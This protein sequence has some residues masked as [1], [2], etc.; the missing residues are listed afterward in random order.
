M[1][2]QKFPLTNSIKRSSLEPKEA[3][4]DVLDS[5]DI[6]AAVAEKWGGGGGGGGGGGLSPLIF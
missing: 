2:E 3:C 4:G 6:S 1:K 5:V